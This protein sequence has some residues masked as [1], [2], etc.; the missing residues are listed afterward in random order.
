MSLIIYLYKLKNYSGNVW[1]I[2]TIRKD[3]HSIITM[4]IEI[5]MYSKQNEPTISYNICPN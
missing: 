2:F 5:L 4:M 3:A 1:F